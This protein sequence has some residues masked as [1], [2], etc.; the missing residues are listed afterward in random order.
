MLLESGAVL[1]LSN[2]LLGTYFLL[3]QCQNEALSDN[4]SSR[5]DY[6]SHISWMAV[7]SLILYNVAFVP[8]WGAIPWILLAEVPPPKARELVASLATVVH[9]MMAFAVTFSFLPAQEALGA[10][11]VF[12]FF[13]AMCFCGIIVVYLLLPETKG[14]SLEEIQEKFA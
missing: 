4:T 13:S 5:Q 7:F 14:K 1:V 2:M 3:A 11:G 6:S 12:Y 9:W 10:A 8:G